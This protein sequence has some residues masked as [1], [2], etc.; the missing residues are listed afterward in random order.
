MTRLL[1]VLVLG[2]AACGPRA[3]IDLEIASAL[4]VPDE[5]DSLTVTATDEAGAEI[6]RGAYRLQSP[7]P[8]HV[9]LEP[10]SATDATI[11]I[12]VTGFLGA[13]EIAR[14]GVRTTW[15]EDAINDVSVTL[16]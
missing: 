16:E 9:I 3:Y 8:Q 10:S 5:V 11:E 15:R 14:S 1:L 13:T 6:G 4:L 7:F 12:W 2:C